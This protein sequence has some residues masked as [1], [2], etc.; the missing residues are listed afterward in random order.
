MKAVRFVG[1][2]QPLEMQEVPI[3]SIGPKDVLIKVKAA[4]ICH[5]DAHYRSGVSYAPAP[6]TFGHE[7]AGIVEQVGSQISNVQPGDRVCLHYLV[8]CGECYYCTSGHEQFCAQG[9]MLGHHID[10]GYAEYI[11]VPA[12]NVV[13]LPDVIP[14]EQGATLMCASATAFHALMKA[15]IRPGDKAAIFGIGG[16]GFSAVQLARAFGA[17]MVFAVDIIEAKLKLAQDFGAIPINGNQVDVVQEIKN[18]TDGRGADIAIEMI[19]LPHTQKQALECTG[20][21]GRAVMVGLSSK[22]I[23][24]NIYKDI[25]GNETELIG[26]N[27]HLLHE[28]PKLID[29][30]AENILDVSKVV[31]KTIPLDADAINATL[32]ALERFDSGVRTVIVMD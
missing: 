12:R 29:F 20:P 18:Y 9:K 5:S 17:T 4:G 23:Q 31:S 19:G 24:L 1:V 16:L 8:T 11:A 27:D 10:G 25:L 2:N 15:R 13:Q 14:F 32:D 26:S 21:L 30:V 28:L 7:I 3:P 22:D 6:L